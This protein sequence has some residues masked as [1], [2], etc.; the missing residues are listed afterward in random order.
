MILVSPT[1]YD[2][3]EFAGAINFTW[4]ETSPWDSPVPAKY[5][6]LSARRLEWIAQVKLNIA[7][8]LHLLDD[9]LIVSKSL[10]SCKNN[11]KAFLQTCDDIGVP[12][13]PE[14]KQ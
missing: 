14:K 12:M 7:G 5:S 1:D 6:N 9:F 2:C 8:I 10:S 4:I 3:L 13:A 11:L